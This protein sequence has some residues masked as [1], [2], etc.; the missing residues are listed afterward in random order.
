MI[1]LHACNSR[2][3]LAIL[4]NFAATILIKFEF[5]K[6]KI[7]CISTWNNNIKENHVFSVVGMHCPKTS[8]RNFHLGVLN[9]Y[10]IHFMA[11][12]NVK[13]PYTVSNV[14][15]HRI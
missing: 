15:L 10:E 9:L 14:L 7:V 8:E 2:I 13:Y 6:Y 5:K 11:L 4:C 1:G 12:L 3:T